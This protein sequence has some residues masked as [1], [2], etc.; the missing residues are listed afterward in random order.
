MRTSEAKI[1]VFLNGG[2]DTFEK[3]FIGTED[4]IFAEA[5]DYQHECCLNYI[6]DNDIEGEFFQDLIINSATHMVTIEEE[7]PMMY[8]VVDIDGYDGLVYGIYPTLADAEEAIFS[9][10]ETYAYEAIMTNDPEDLFGTTEWDYKNDSKWLMKDTAR[11]FKIQ[12]VP[13]F[14]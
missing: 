12:M 3:Y 9:E 4:E 10:A 2:T 8:A 6:N 14:E 11:C 5:L 1:T 13:I 7:P